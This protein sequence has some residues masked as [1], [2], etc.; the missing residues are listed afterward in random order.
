[1]CVCVFFFKCTLFLAVPPPPTY[2]NLYQPTFKPVTVVIKLPQLYPTFRNVVTVLIN[3]HVLR[4]V[5]VIVSLCIVIPTL[6]YLFTVVVVIVYLYYL[7]C[8]NY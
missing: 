3:L 2:T 8:P 4:V 6:T 5:V 1:M 7:R